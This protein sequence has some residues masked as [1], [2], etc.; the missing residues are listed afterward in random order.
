MSK[1]SAPKPPDPQKTA[2]AQTGTNLATAIANT[3][4]GQVN[5]VTPDGSL[6]YAQTGMQT[7]TGPDGKTYNV[8]Q[9]TATTT[10]S[11]PAQKIRDANNSASLNL[12]NLAASQSSR[13]GDLLSRP[14]DTTQAPAMADRSG[15]GPAQYGQGPNAPTYETVQRSGDYQD[16]GTG[17]S[18]QRQSGDAGLVDTYQ[19]DFTADRQRVEDALYSRLNP[20]L[21]LQRQQIQREL[22]GRGVK[23]GSAA[24]DRAMQEYGQTANDA[25]FG[26][27]M[28]AGAE[29]QR[30][31]NE[32]R[33]AAQFT[34]DARQT[35]YGNAANQNA[36]NN[37][38]T[39]QERADQVATTGYN[40]T[41]VGQRLSDAMATAG[42]NNQ[43]A[44]QTFGDQMAVTARND[45]NANNTVAQRMGL[46]DALD[47]QRSQYLQEQFAIRNQPINEITALLSGSQVQTP[48]FGI[49][50]PAQMPTTD[51]AGITQQGYQNSFA[52][53][54]QKMNQYNATMG[55]LFDMGAAAIGG[56]LFTRPATKPA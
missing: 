22:A 15:I 31:Q 13:A 47:R 24:Y 10:L 32:A 54:Q 56:P 42:F 18:Y 46:A 43:A 40:N 8:P 1:P 55:G 37:N 49:A 45:A 33:A 29:Q 50:Q 52:N 5:Q 27:I 7:F 4:M 14:M 35:T 12:A 51:V 53:Y 48:Q 3:Q 26:A 9:Y 19:N 38:L 11:E 28:N 23:Q 20:Q 6:T 30:L 17:P 41:L 36:Y 44:G 39:A 21:D 16:L 34:N 2:E 25:R